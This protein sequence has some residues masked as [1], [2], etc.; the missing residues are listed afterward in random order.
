[1]VNREG[2]PVKLTRNESERKTM[3]ANTNKVH[4]LDRKELWPYDR[5]W[6]CWDLRKPLTVWGNAAGGK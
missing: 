2:H 1:M 6:A 4:P 3:P 5:K